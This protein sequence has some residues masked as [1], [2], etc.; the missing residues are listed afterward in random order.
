VAELSRQEENTAAA[1]VARQEECTAVAQARQEVYTLVA[2][3]QQEVCTLV[4]PAQLEVH[5]AVVAAALQ[6]QQQALV[7]YTAAPAVQVCTLPA[8]FDNPKIPQH[9]PKAAAVP[10]PLQY[11]P[12]AAARVRATQEPVAAHDNMND[13][14]QQ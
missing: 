10:Q 9:Q 7:G 4:A 5:I 11:Q 8:V 3:A 13:L 6:Q 1:L 14:H 12:R 2:Q